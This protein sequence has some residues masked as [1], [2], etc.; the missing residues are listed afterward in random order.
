M[1]IFFPTPF[2]LNMRLISILTLWNFQKFPLLFHQTPWNFLY[3]WY[4]PP[5]KILSM[6]IYK[7]TVSKEVFALAIYFFIVF[8]FLCFYRD[9]PILCYANK[10]FIK[11]FYYR[12]FIDW[13]CPFFFVVSLLHNGSSIAL[14]KNNKVLLL[15]A[16][17]LTQDVTWT[18]IQCFLNVMDVRLKQQRCVLTGLGLITLFYHS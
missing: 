3:W 17:L 13:S 9:L 7:K 12:I 15:S 4:T 8:D 1:T 5:L 18:S 16:S 2:L 6:F 10:C 14:G 11:D